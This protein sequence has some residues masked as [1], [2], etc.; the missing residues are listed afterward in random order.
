MRERI[1]RLSAEFPYLVYEKNGKV[2]GFCY[3]HRWKDRAAYDHTL[4]TTIYLSPAFQH[5]GIGTLL[6]KRLV[7]ECRSMG[8]VVL[9]ACITYGNEASVRMHEKLGFEQVSHFKRV[10]MKFGRYLD[11]VDL[12]LVL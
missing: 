3:A 6:M 5:Q 11:V 4:E 10:G 2:G 1:E 12:Q 8:I 9:V 7:S